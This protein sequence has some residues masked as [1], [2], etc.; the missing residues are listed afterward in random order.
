MKKLTTIFFALGFGVSSWA[1]DFKSGDL[2]YNITSSVEPYTVAVTY[3][4]VGDS[5]H[6]IGSIYNY[7]GLTN[8]IIP[9]YVI[10]NQKKYLVTSIG[11]QAFH[12]ASI[13]SII[14]PNT[15][16]TLGVQSLNFGSSISK[17]TIPA[18]ITSIPFNS[19]AYFKSD[20][21]CINADTI[22][23]LNPS[24]VSVGQ[25]LSSSG[26]YFGITGSPV[27]Y[28]PCGSREAYDKNLFFRNGL[29]QKIEEFLPY[30]LVVNVQNSQAGIVTTSQ[31]C[32][33]SHII[34]AIPK[35]GNTF[36]KW[37][38]GNTQATRYIELTQDTTLTA[39]FA[40]E[41]YTIHVYQ[42]CNT[43]IE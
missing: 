9:E 31:I 38:D 42:D 8:V 18:S 7:D 23:F 33:T 30:S 15:V 17:I 37:S 19:S 32:C 12:D 10:Y 25:Y 4:T 22:V 28:I 3:E 27:C 41:G 21:N 1:Y 35:D 24:G 5:Y 11:T 16:T 29:P 43:T 14:I 13:K 6:C 26:D 2:Y 36:V 40:K 20:G 34:T 39:Y